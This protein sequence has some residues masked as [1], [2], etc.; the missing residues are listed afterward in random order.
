MRNLTETELLNL[1][2]SCMDRPLIETSLHLIATASSDKDLSNVASL[3]IGQRDARLLQLR[4]WMFGGRLKNVA[5]CPHCSEKIEW[6]NDV[7]ELRLQPLLPGVGKIFDVKIDAYHI[8]FRLPTTHDL[9]HLK[10]SSSQKPANELLNRCITSL[11]RENETVV[12]S[13]LPVDIIEEIN[14]LMS[15]KDPQADIIMLLTCPSCEKQWESG[16]DILSYLW[17]EINSWAKNILREIFILAKFFG[18]SEREILEIGPKRRQ[19][20]LEMVRA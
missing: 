8:N 17:S 4:E 14:D 13:D 10:E 18:W 1:W 19:L 7:K 20:Y 15:K 16:F 12:P 9:F 5:K 6:E 11:R 2:E 3:S